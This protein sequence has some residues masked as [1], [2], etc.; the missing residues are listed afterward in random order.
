MGILKEHYKKIGKTGG[1][2]TF[3]N[4][5]SEY[6]KRISKLGVIARKKKQNDNNTIILNKL[7]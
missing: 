7:S 1:L 6:F 5:G 4:R 3:K 2:A